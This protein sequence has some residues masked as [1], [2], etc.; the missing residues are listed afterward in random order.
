[1][2]RDE[3]RTLEIPEE[4]R[5]RAAF[6]QRELAR[7]GRLYYVEDAPEIPDDE[8]DALYRELVGLE[9]A[10]PE[11]ASPESP[12]KRVGAKA[13]E[14]FEKVSLSVPMLSLD[15]A[16]N[17][18]DLDGFL[19]RTAP[20][21]AGGYVCELKID[22]LAVSL[23]YE[24]GAFVRGTTRGDGRVGEDITANLRTIRTLPLTLS[25]FPRGRVEVRGEVLLERKYFAALNEEREERGEP[26]FA[27]PRNA[28]A[29]SLR[30]LDPA[31]TAGRRLSV[32]LYSLVSPEHLGLASQ[33][34][35]LEWLSGAG[36]PVQ[37]AWQFCPDGAAVREFIAA[38]E[39]A[40]FS[41]PYAT[42]GVVVKLDSLDAWS[43]MGSTSHAPRWAV[44]FK[45]PPEEKTTRLTDILVSVGRT[46]ALTPVA[47]LE[48]VT[49]SGSVVRRAS[50]HNEDELRR[51][52]L[53]IGDLV[54]VR[55]AGE[56]I[57][58][59]LGAVAELRNGTE[60]EFAMPSACPSCGSPAVRLEGEA[61][62]RCLNR[63]SC[64]A[65]LKE[66]IRHFASRG[67]MDIR[68]LG[69][70]LVEQLVDKG[71]V[72]TVSDL[73]RL[74][75]DA[76]AG[77]ERMGA[78]S[79]ENLLEAVGAS[80]ERPFSRLLA[81]LGIRFVG[82]RGAEILAE[83]FR[84]VQTLSEAP[85]EALAAVEGIGPVMAASIRSFF[86]REQNRKL[87]EELAEL[88]LR[89]ALPS[90]KEQAGNQG[91]RFLEGMRIV[92]TGE[93]ESLTRSE[94]EALAKAAGAVC[95]SSV[96][97]KTS[98]VVAGKEAGSKLAKAA[99]LGVPIAGEEEFLEMIRSGRT[100]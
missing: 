6:L 62:L 77:L 96:S 9:A 89:G 4:A 76:V 55:K 91:P 42:D 94:A 2:P 12:T 13:S 84:D 29:G 86:D 10:W 59:V 22:G 50:L 5:R 27:N 11:L 37:K 16:L 41:L 53:R 97:G 36:F 64:P 7:H 14:R 44:A 100:S 46:G 95:S 35:I 61:A 58:E 93:L 78:K 33:R 21:A 60:R 40:R 92:F 49:L 80:K 39:E 75:A 45:Y 19:N 23:T 81:A 88:G 83:A 79:A 67:G 66:G 1:M 18:E 54:R 57:P 20:R 31:V 47:V 48:P 24:D 25:D 15:N 28:A 99:A 69:D 30:Q 98:L 8:Y 56:I 90:P 70:R 85:E 72:R 87:L 26:L 73:Y 51:K 68:G 17:G 71:I 74:P 3:E 82:S 65:Q 38:W 52:D 43:E 63:A 34:G 32:F